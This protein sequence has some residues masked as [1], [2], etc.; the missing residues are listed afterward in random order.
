MLIDYWG[1]KPEKEIAD[2]VR[3]YTHLV[4]S[5]IVEIGLREP[6]GGVGRPKEGGCLHVIGYI[7]SSVG[8]GRLEIKL[9]PLDAFAFLGLARKILD[10]SGH[11]IRKPEFPFTY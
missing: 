5:Q 6:N 3:L 2:A 11:S 10:G 1:R 7:A 4:S 9:H 8:R